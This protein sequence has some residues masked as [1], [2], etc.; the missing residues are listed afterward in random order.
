MFGNIN[1]KQIEGVMKRMGISQIPVDAKRV[2]IEKEDSRT[3]ID[4][5]SITKVTMQ[6]Q[7]T[8]QI[9]GMEREE[10]Q[11]SSEDEESSEEITEEDVEMVVAQTNVS[12]EKAREILDK[13]NGDIASAIIELK[14]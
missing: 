2:I 11:D 5:P 12:K 3:I 1:P 8:Y 10:S 14:K 4:E 6:G 7:T 9:T 13:H